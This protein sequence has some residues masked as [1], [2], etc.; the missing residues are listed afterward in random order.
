M[1]KLLIYIFLGLCSLHCRDRYAY[2]PDAPDRGMLVVEALINIDGNTDII[3]SRTSPLSKSWIIPEEAASVTIEG[4]DNSIY[5]F[6]EGDSGHYTTPALPLSADRKYRMRII[7][8]DSKEY[9]S[10]FRHPLRTQEVDSVTYRQENDLVSFYAHS[11]EDTAATYYFKYEWEET[12]QFNSSFRTQLQYE[13]RVAAGDTQVSVVY[14]D[15]VNHSVKESIYACWQSRESTTIDLGTT[16]SLTESKIFLPV[17]TLRRDS[18]ELSFLY[19]I[20]VRQ[21]ALSADGYDFYRRMK[22]NTESLGSIFDAQPSDI[23]GNIKCVTDPDEVVVGFV[24]FTSAKEKRIFVRS[25]DLP[26]DVY[27]PG[28]TIY[29]GVGAKYPYPFAN[30]PEVLKYVYDSLDLLPVNLREPIPGEI[31]F[32][33][34][35]ARCVDCTL[36]GSN[37]KPTF[38][39]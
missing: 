29:K 30:E 10:D 5:S 16:E 20:L 4:E 32:I 27:D 8:S 22:K 23:S 7:T 9:L 28:C 39:P 3:L 37:V 31:Y 11:A 19:S 18:W 1:K 34:E 2:V 35:A 6:A 12:W 36:N 21:Y 15:P 25:E 26:G 17:R 38:W 14:F 13:L 33:M 24:E